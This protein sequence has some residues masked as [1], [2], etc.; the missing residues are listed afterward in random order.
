MTRI[1]L[2]ISSSISLIYDSAVK[3]IRIKNKRLLYLKTLAFPRKVMTNKARRQ[4][5]CWMASKKKG[6]I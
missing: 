1:T 3:D 6:A 5:A 2:N 4:D